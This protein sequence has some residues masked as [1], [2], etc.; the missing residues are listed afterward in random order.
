MS[1]Y[2]KEKKKEDGELYNLMEFIINCCGL[3]INDTVEREW[4]NTTGDEFFNI[5]FVE[6]LLAQRI[7]YVTDSNK[8]TLHQKKKIHNEFGLP[9]GR[10]KDID[11]IECTINTEIKYILTDDT[12]FFDPKK[13]NASAKEKTRVKNLRQGELCKFLRKEFGIIVGLPDHCCGDLKSKGVISG[14]I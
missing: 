14:Q 4:R 7:T 1:Y 5:W 9:R 13:K 10:S 3:A 12:D 2:I 8:L 11:Y 6:Y